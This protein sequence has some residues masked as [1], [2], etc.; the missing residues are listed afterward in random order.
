MHTR[1]YKL[2]VNDPNRKKFEMQLN[3]INQTLARSPYLTTQEMLTLANDAVAL[4]TVPTGIKLFQRLTETK[5][6]IPAETFAKAGKYALYISD[7]RASAQLYFAAQ[8]RAQSTE[9]KRE[10][11]IDALKSLQAGGLDEEAWDA[12]SKHIGPLIND[13]KTLEYIVHLS[14]KADKPEKALNYVN[15]LLHWSN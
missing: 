6:T 13:Y 9:K 12:A 5:E 8:D 7:Y 14:I 3:T 4:D 15:Q 10:Y 11:F 1:A 2:Q